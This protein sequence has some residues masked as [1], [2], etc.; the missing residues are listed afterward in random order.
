MKN[1]VKGKGG[2]LFAK[3]GNSF[4]SAIETTITDNRNIVSS[5]IMYNEFMIRVITIYGPQ[6]NDTTEVKQKFY[7]DLS[8]E[9]ENCVINGGVPIVGGDLNAKIM[10]EDENIVAK[11]SNGT[12]LK[13]LIEKHNLRVINFHDNTEGF[14]TRTQVKDGVTERSVIDYILC[15]DELY[16]YIDYMLI[17]EKKALTPFSSKRSRNGTAVT[18]SDHS[19][20]IA[21]II[22][23]S[24]LKEEM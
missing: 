20:I 19:A 15:G 1:D 24:V 6:E 8:I 4:S 2:L 10:K 16:D 11:S 21:M 5:Q 18:Y 14:Y 22:L 13:Q 3:K 7:E 17:D 12:L 23:P 9:I